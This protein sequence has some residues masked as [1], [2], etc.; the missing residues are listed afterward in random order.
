MLIT[1]RCLYNTASFISKILSY[2]DTPQLDFGWF[3]GLKLAAVLYAISCY[4][5]P[6][7]LETRLYCFQFIPLCVKMWVNLLYNFHMF[8]SVKKHT[9]KISLFWS[10]HFT[11]T[12]LKFASLQNSVKHYFSRPIHYSD[13]IMSAM[14]SEITGVSIVCSAVCSGADQ[15]NIKN[16][17]HRPLRGESTGDQW[18]P[19]PKGQ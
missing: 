10:P 11:V 5:G 17:R 4:I 8:L 3:S 14:V 1:I 7:Y 2:L 9:T 18:I 16:P 13:D 19:L 12:C 6:R 15:R